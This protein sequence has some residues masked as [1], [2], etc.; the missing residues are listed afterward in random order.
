MGWAGII[1]LL[2]GVL[3]GVLLELA[4]IRQ[5]NAYQYG[6]FLVM[7]LEVPL[8][9]G[10]GW[11]VILYSA[12]MYSDAT[13]LPGWARPMLDG[14][15]ALNIDL[16]MDAIAIR[17]GMWDWGMGLQAEYFGVPYANFWAWL[18][19]VASF[20]AGYRLLSHRPDWMGRWGSPL[21]AVIVG[22][23]GVLATNYFIAF[24]V[25]DSIYPATV[26]LTLGGVLV[27]VIALRPRVQAQ[28]MPAVAIWVPAAFHLYFLAAG[29]IS[30]AIF[31]PPLLLLMSLLM[32]ALAVLLHAP[33]LW[34]GRVRQAPGAGENPG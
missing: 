26:A 25:P 13:A 14:L 8:A 29:I 27:T 32:L 22:L 24:L 15:L 18:W 12:M 17:L 11:G 6:R 31:D 4:T 2:A 23:A 10:A 1:R 21:A 19:V 34:A 30:G 16:A 9:I 5:L 3:F 7:V 28:R 33:A 20:S